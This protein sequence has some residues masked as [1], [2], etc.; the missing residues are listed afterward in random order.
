[1]ERV[2]VYTLWYGI[3]YTRMVNARLN[4]VRYG[5]IIIVNKL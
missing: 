1:M 4:E 3:I 2:R 5:F